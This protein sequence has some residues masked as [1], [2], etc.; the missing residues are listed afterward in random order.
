LLPIY[1]LIYNGAMRTGFMV[2]LSPSER[3]LLEAA[4][5]PEETVAAFMRRVSL[6]AAEAVLKL[7]VKT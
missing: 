4:A 2:R 6:R 7:K 5:Q 1:I 3:A